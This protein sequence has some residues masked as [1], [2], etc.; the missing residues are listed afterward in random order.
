MSNP[1]AGIRTALSLAAVCFVASLMLPALADAVSSSPLAKRVADTAMLMWG[2]FGVVSLLGLPLV[3]KYWGNAYLVCYMAG[4][5]LA[6]WVGFI[7]G[8]EFIA[9]TGFGVVLIFQRFGRD[10]D[11]W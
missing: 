7:D 9:T 4:I 10:Y 8:L 1:Q 3:M 11:R 5:C 6:L 2:L